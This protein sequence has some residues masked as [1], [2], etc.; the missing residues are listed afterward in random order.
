MMADGRAN[1]G[2]NVSRVRELSPS[3]RLDMDFL[4]LLAHRAATAGVMAAAPQGATVEPVLEPLATSLLR[5]SISRANLW[6]D[7]S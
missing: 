6:L 4:A 2:S 1:G 5:M 7:G 3:S